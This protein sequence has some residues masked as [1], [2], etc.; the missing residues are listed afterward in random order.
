MDK[1]V[2][3]QCMETVSKCGEVFGKLNVPNGE[4]RIL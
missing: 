2:I 3:R 1:V 4:N